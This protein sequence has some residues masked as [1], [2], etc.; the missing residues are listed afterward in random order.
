MVLYG[1]VPSGTVSVKLVNASTG[2]IVVSDIPLSSGFYLDPI[3]SS[4]SGGNKVE[5]FNGA[6]NEVGTAPG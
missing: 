1:K 6:G 5:F 2:V 4:S 3:P